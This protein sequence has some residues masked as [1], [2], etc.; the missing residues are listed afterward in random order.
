LNCTLKNEHA[1]HKINLK[2]RF[3]K[4]EF[5]AGNSG[6]ILKS[7]EKELNKKKH[8]EVAKIET[9]H[10]GAHSK[11]FQ[12]FQTATNTAIDDNKHQVPAACGHQDNLCK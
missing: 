12:F 5:N 10:K 1:V 6:K 8:S 7:I 2:V 4:N 9:M 3:Y 11:I